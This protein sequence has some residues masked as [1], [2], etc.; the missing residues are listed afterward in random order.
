MLTELEI[1]NFRKFERYEVVFGPRNLL[2]GPNNAGKSTLIEALRLLSIVVN[3]VTALSYES[4][5]DWLEHLRLA[6]G[7]SPSLRGMDF[8]LG[9]ETFHQYADPPATI[10]GRFAN[11]AA[12]EVYVGAGADV[13]AVVRDRDGAALT[14]KAHA[15]HFGAPTLGIQPQVG[16]LARRE[17]PLGDRYVRGA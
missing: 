11:G 4:P 12:V 9:R 7:V 2:V 10:V 3:R 14:S 6:K 1:R 13:F 15:R 8:D 16:P 17:R 5:P